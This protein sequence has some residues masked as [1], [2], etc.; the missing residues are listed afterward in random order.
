MPITLN[1]GSFSQSATR[2]Q[3]SLLS[4]PNSPRSS[5]TRFRLDTADNPLKRKRSLEL[6]ESSKRSRDGLY[7]TYF[8]SR[9]SSSA[10]SLIGERSPQPNEALSS[11]DDKDMQNL[12]KLLDDFTVTKQKINYFAVP[13]SEVSDIQA[14]TTS[15]AKV[16]V[17]SERNYFLA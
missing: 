6:D 11:N 8:N 16:T 5:P 9:R 10:S 14:L 1:V 17:T 13:S 7:E 3:G 12:A 4:P 2:L 15:L